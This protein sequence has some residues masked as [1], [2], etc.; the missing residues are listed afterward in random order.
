MI[1]VYRHAAT[2]PIYYYEGVSLLNQ[3]RVDGSSSRARFFN[4]CQ[5]APCNCERSYLVMNQMRIA[6]LTLH[7][8]SSTRKIY[9]MKSKILNLIVVTL[10]QDIYAI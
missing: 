3:N 4:Q 1:Y 8:R 7:L 5:G 10:I 6:A 2:C 9:K